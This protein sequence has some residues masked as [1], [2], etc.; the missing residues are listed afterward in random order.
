MRKSWSA[1]ANVAPSR[2]PLAARL[3]YTGREIVNAGRIDPGVVKLEQGTDGDGVVNRLFAPTR[4]FQTINVLATKHVRLRIHLLDEREECL[5]TTI[6]R[7]RTVVLEHGIDEASVAQELRRD[8]GVRTDSKRTIVAARC[9]RSD[10]LSLTGRERRRSAH[11]AL[12]ELSEV[13]GPIWL[14]RE[15]MHDL[16]DRCARLAHLSNGLRP[17]T[18]AVGVFD[19]R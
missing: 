11:H 17:R 4:P 13:L 15:E 3:V 8:R 5:L 16:W 9:E 1:S 12:R 14:K 18:C 10:Q 2:Q 6:D 7:R 19:F